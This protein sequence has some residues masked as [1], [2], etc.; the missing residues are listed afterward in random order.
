MAASHI[1]IDIVRQTYAALERGDAPTLVALSSPDIVVYQSDLIPWGGRHSGH[2]G[3]KQF[4]QGVMSRVD[5]TIETAELYSAG[6][7]VVQV[8]RTRGTVRATGK[9]FDAAETHIWR[10]RDDK[11]VAFEA[12]VDTDE[13]TRALDA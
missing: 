2:D 12:Y 11:I 6:D 1:D 9:T 4:L 10:V 7:R 5:S 13:L 3:L 8:G